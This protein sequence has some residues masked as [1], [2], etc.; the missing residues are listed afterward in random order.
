MN[1]FEKFIDENYLAHSNTTY[2]QD[3]HLSL[4]CI[5]RIYSLLISEQ[6]H[7]RLSVYLSDYAPDIELDHSLAHAYDM[8]QSH[9]TL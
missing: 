5:G 2:T 4:D 6:N 9:I 7:S 3:S 1:F 8:S